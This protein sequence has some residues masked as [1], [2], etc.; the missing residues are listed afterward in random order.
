VIAT[1][2]R[3]FYSHFGIDL[4]GIA[5]A[6]VA[7]LRAGHVVQGGSTITQQ[8]AK[9]LF[10]TPDRTMLRKAQEMVLAVWLEHRFTKDQLLGIYL[11]RVYF[12]AGAYG[13]DAA[14]RRYFGKSARRL[15]LYECATIAGLLKAPSKFSPAGNRKRA[16]ERTAQVL[17]NMVDAG[18]LTDADAQSAL[19]QSIVLASVPVT[20]PGMRYFADWVEDQAVAG[21]YNGDLVVTTTLDPP[22]QAAAEQVIDSMLTR[23]GPKAEASQG[24]LIAMSPDGAIRAM[25]GGRDYHESQFNRVTQATRQPGSA[26]KP[27]VYLTALEQGMQPTDRFIDGPVR[28]GDWQPHNYETGYRGEVSMADAVAQ[29]INTVAV[30]VGQSVGLRNVIAVAR[31]LGITTEL[32]PDPSL[33]LGTGEVTLLDLTTAYCA[34]ASGGNG[35]W[36][37]GITEIRDGGGKLL[38]ARQGGG[39]GRVIEPGFVDEMDQMLSGVIA[40]GTGKAAQIG[41]PAAGKTGTTSDF[42]DALFVGYTADLVAGVWFG[43]DDDAPMNHV[44]GGS[45]P[46]RAW[47]DFMISALRNKPARPLLQSGPVAAD[48]PFYAVL[49]RA[50]QNSIAGN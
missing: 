10:L 9:N 17:A 36:P 23:D 42:R 43:N 19:K 25:V 47:H 33:A 45:L 15:N 21:G 6:A 34:F 44:S 3:R 49:Q 50:Q 32:N 38:F 35:A 40:H 13:V 8:L 41:R 2:D 5:R 16:S 31:R 28:I 24:A 1:E 14:S 11:N 27:F 26:F 12:G 37:Y 29:S 4:I 39:P 20:Q 22:M 7:N 46:A 30:K 18:Y 48:D